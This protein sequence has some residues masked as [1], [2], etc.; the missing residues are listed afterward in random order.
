MSEPREFPDKLDEGC[1]KKKAVKDDFNM[2]GLNSRT[3]GVAFK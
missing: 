3:D 2:F 1:E